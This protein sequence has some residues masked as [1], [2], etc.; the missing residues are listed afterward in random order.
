MILCRGNSS[1]QT[2]QMNGETHKV[3]RAV[4]STYEYFAVP[5]DWNMDDITVRYDKLYYKGN[6]INGITSTMDREYPDEITE[7]DFDD[8]DTY[9]DCD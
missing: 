6:V 9:F 2:I 8:F 4:Y 5:K 3:I 1:I 7:E